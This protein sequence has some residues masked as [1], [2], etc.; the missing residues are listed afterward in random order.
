MSARGLSFS[1][2]IPLIVSLALVIVMTVLAVVGF[3]L[4]GP[5]IRPRFTAFQIGTLLFFLAFMDAVALLPATSVVKADEDGLRIRNGIRTHV[6]PW[7]AVQDIRMTGGDSWA[8]VHLDPEWHPD[9]IDRR[10]ILGIQR[11]DGARA[12]AAVEALR[13]YAAT[14]APNWRGSR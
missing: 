7:D 11:T 9:N 8:F 14:R 1:P 5:E 2:R 6:L 10:M 3:W 12:R 13:E 4:L